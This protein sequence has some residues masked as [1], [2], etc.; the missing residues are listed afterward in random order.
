MIMVWRSPDLVW[1]SRPVYMRLSKKVKGSGDSRIC[2]CT[3]GMQLLTEIR[4]HVTY[5]AIVV[6]YRYFYNGDY[7]NDLHRLWKT[8]QMRKGKHTPCKPIANVG[9]TRT[10]EASPIESRKYGKTSFP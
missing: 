1:R 6:K 4:K 5:F 8:F 10:T 9:Q 2:T 7:Y 3:R